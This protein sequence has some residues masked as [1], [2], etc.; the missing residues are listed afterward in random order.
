MLPQWGVLELLVL[1]GEL[2]PFRIFPNVCNT[3]SEVCDLKAKKEPQQPRTCISYFY[4]TRLASQFS[5][6]S[7]LLQCVIIGYLNQLRF[8][9]TVLDS[10]QNVIL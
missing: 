8:F 6:S 7:V 10:H 4:V 3:T 2:G 9:T 5:V 1:E